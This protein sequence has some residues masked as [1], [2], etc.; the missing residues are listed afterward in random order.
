MEA[1][2]KHLERE[3]EAKAREQGRSKSK[4]EHKWAEQELDRF[5]WLLAGNRVW[6]IPGCC[7]VTLEQ[8]LDRKLTVTMGWIW[9]MHIILCQSLSPNMADKAT[10]WLL[11]SLH[12]IM[13]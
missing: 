11:K 9:S 7:P 10:Y 12:Q 13:V 3:G 1:G 6:S 5:T 4:R 8:S 2:L